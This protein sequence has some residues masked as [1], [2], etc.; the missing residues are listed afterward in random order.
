MKSQTQT[1]GSRR[2]SSILNNNLKT[3]MK[4]IMSVSKLTFQI[5]I[6]AVLQRN[7]PSRI[8]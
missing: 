8:S 5:L 3:E 1:D 4:K 6:S 7:S 2:L